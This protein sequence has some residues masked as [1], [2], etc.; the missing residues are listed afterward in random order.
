MRAR[1]IVND[2]LANRASAQKGGKAVSTSTKIAQGPSLALH[3]G[4][5]STTLVLPPGSAEEAALVPQA[6]HIVVP[7]GR[8]PLVSIERNKFADVIGD[9]VGRA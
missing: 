6:Q 7:G 5:V 1:C 8:A 9:F 3:A 2:S 4:G